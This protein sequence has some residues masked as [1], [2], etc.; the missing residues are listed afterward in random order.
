MPIPSALMTVNN[1][2]S[3][4]HYAVL[5]QTTLGTSPST[6]VQMLDDIFSSVKERSRIRTNISQTIKN[7]IY[8]FKK[9]K[10]STYLEELRELY[11]YS[12]RQFCNYLIVDPTYLCLINLIIELCEQC[13]HGLASWTERKI[14]PFNRAI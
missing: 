2:R 10:F 5:I 14:P 7:V 3:I 4:C 12:I 9:L 8:E 11:T 6:I 1:T 13:F